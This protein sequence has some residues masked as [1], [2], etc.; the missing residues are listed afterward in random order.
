MGHILT[1]TWLKYIGKSP[2]D[3][4][5]ECQVPDTIDHLLIACKK[6]DISKLIL[7]K[8]AQRKVECT[9]KNILSNPDVYLEVYNILMNITNGKIM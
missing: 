7:E 2:T 4:C 1:N 6:H 5:S 9:V 3:L 8:C